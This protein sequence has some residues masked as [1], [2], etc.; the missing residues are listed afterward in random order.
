MKNADDSR[1][2]P[3]IAPQA[4]RTPTHWAQISAAARRAGAEL[5]WC[6]A[7]A[8]ISACVAV[9]C[10]AHNAPRGTPMQREQSYLDPELPA[11]RR[12]ELLLAQMTLEEKVGQMCQYVGEVAAARASN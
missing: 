4:R 12:T 1:R 5:G 8:G 3:S 2:T 9:G 11:Q 7:I 10:S 6:A